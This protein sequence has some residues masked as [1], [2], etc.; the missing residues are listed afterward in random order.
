MG[1]SFLQ[2]FHVWSRGPLL[3]WDQS[4]EVAQNMG[5]ALTPQHMTH[6]TSMALIFRSSWLPSLRINQKDLETRHERASPSSTTETF[7]RLGTIRVLR[8]DVWDC[9]G[10]RKVASGAGLGWLDVS[11]C[12]A[13]EKKSNQFC[14]RVIFPQHYTFNLLSRL[15]EQ[16]QKQR[17]RV[18]EG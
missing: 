2:S 1:I 3:C 16:C 18:S 4:T 7:G 14:I 9:L 12:C 8:E 6:F 15:P 10:Y 11:S 5:H 13:K 17:H